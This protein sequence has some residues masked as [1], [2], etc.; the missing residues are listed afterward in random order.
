M[1]LKCETPKVCERFEIAFLYY[2]RE[3]F[4]NKEKSFGF[5]ISSLEKDANLLSQT[6]AP[7]IFLPY[8]LDHVTPENLHSGLHFR[9]Q[10]C[11]R[12]TSLI[13]CGFEKWKVKTDN[14]WHHLRMIDGLDKPNIYTKPW[15]R[16][17]FN[18]LKIFVWRAFL[19]AFKFRE[20]MTRDFLS[21]QYVMW[22]E[23]FAVWLKH[24]AGP[25]SSVLEYGFFFWEIK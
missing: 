22:Q 6:R 15:L 16:T 23:L 2:Y 7:M 5:K 24:F 1:T 25:K 21:L 10:F 4:F 20:I 14:L 13:E 3:I 9:S 12:W 8:Y 11:E 17:T 18:H 19:G